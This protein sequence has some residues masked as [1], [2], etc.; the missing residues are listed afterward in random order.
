MPG[1]C[2]DMLHAAAYMLTD[3][4]YASCKMESCISY[5]EALKYVIDNPISDEEY[6]E[7]FR[8]FFCSLIDAEYYISKY[9]KHMNT[10]IFWSEVEYVAD[11]RTIN[12][13]YL[14]RIMLPDI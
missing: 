7:I 6:S 8:E 4:I 10:S 2:Y 1:K 11:M 13:D 14:H 12:P 9:V 5:P 3:I